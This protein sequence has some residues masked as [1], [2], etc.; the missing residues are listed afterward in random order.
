MAR[1]IDPHNN[2]FPH[3]PRPPLFCLPVN[4]PVQISHLSFIPLL[5]FGL[6]KPSHSVADQADNSL[7][8]QKVHMLKIDIKEHIAL[9]TFKE[10]V[11]GDSIV[12]C[13]LRIAVTFR[14]HTFIFNRKSHC[15]R[16]EDM[17]L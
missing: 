17:G 3:P 6:N 11:L 1:L 12:A 16:H 4:D 5:A 2:S 14:I 15:V 13:L 10:V 8:G 9:K 7:A